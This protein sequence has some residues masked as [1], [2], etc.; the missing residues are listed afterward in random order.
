MPY[1]KDGVAIDITTEYGE[2]QRQLCNKC[3]VKD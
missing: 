2:W 3:H 1:Y